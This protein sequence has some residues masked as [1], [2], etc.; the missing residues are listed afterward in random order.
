MACTINL[1]YKKSGMVLPLCKWLCTS[2][3]MDSSS[4]IVMAISSTM[5][6]VSVLAL[7]ASASCTALWSNTSVLIIRN[8]GQLSCNDV[9]IAFFAWSETPN[10]ARRTGASCISTG[11]LGSSGKGSLVHAVS[12]KASPNMYLGAVVKSLSTGTSTLP[13]LSETLPIMG[14]TGSWSILSC[15]A[16]AAFSS[17]VSSTGAASTS[18]SPSSVEGALSSFWSSDGASFSLTFFRDSTAL[19]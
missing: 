18:V 8:W 3:A 9:A 13:F 19:S 2:I 17:S 15:S 12:T 11:G 7:T 6:S 5:L 1:I 16:L 10:N 14:I 4:V